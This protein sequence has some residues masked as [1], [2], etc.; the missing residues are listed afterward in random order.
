MTA[1]ESNK[2]PATYKGVDL[3]KF[4]FAVCVVCIHTQ[5]LGLLPELGER[6]V[7]SGLLRLAVPYFFV[8]SGYF[9]Y[10]KVIKVG[11]EQA[12]SV[13]GGYCLRLLKPFIF[14]TVINTAQKLISLFGQGVK[15]V[16]AAII[17]FK[18]A[19][20]YPYGALWFVLACIVGALLL[21]PFLRWGKIWPAIIIGVALYSFAL[22]CNNYYFLIE[23]T[24][25]GRIVNAYM[26][27]FTSARNGLFV[28]FVFLA[29]GSFSCKISDTVLKHKRVLVF[30]TAALYLIY[31]AEFMTLLLL[32]CSWLDD[33][34]L[35]I[36][37]LI[38]VP[39]LFLTT[40]IINPPIPD[41]LSLL[42]RNLSVGIYYLHRP[43][44]WCSAL[45]FSHPAINFPLVLVVSVGICLAAYSV[46]RKPAWISGL[47]K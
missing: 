30:V 20:V 17:V 32:G 1:I 15:V 41:K 13:V 4:I 16:D 21:F 8:A 12:W 3:V 34:A 23:G 5:I 36:T 9:M 6:I 14:F 7:T 47:L 35:Y 40:L 46:R 19:H 2:A 43:I 39:A 28:G 18:A 38:M 26:A 33:R 25:V 24:V 10:K 45:I 42:F 29:L 31:V 37:Q 27:E 44:L 11:R 22:I